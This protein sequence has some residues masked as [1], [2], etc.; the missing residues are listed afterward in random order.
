MV[1][2]PSTFSSPRP[3]QY[4]YKSIHC[5]SWQASHCRFRKAERAG[6]CGAGLS[7]RGFLRLILVGEGDLGRV[8]GIKTTS[9]RT[10]V[11][12]EETQR[13]ASMKG[14]STSFGPSRSESRQ[15]CRRLVRGSSAARAMYGRFLERRRTAGKVGLEPCIGTHTT[16][17]CTPR[18]VTTDI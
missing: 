12:V 9:V 13:M 3:H 5:G 4:S 10:R 16:A 14:A 7:L 8:A 18:T 17:W 1:P 11:V 2:G 15:R 6:R